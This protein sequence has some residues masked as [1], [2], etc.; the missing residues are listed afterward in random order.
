MDLTD[1]Q[2]F[3]T[4]ELAAGFLPV[5][6]YAVIRAY[7]SAQGTM[8]DR[9]RKLVAAIVY[10]A[11]AL[12]GNAIE[13]AFDGLSWDTAEDVLASVMKVAVAGFVAYK[14]FGKAGGLQQPTAPIDKVAYGDRRPAA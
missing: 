4:W 8:T 3:Q 7:E 14:A 6:I 2:A 5:L 10:V 1:T 9:G 12:I 13:G 11:Y